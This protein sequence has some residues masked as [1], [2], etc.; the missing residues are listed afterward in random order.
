MRKAIL[1]LLLGMAAVSPVH[2]AEKKNTGCYA[3]ALRNLQRL[4]PRG[5]AVYEAMP[6]KKQFLHWITCGDVPLSLTTAVHE[7]V[8]IMTEQK[9]G[10]V[11]LDGT[12][13]RRP[14]ALSKFYPPRQI[15]GAFDRNDIHVQTYLRPGAASSAQ[16]ATYLLD[17]LNAYTHDLNTAI[18][19]VPM[20]K[21]RSGEAAH[22]D[23][24]SAL[25]AFVM[26]YVENAREKNTATWQGLK[27]PETTKVVRTLWDQAEKVLASSCGIRG[28]G[29]NDK[30]HISFM[31][32][33]K[34]SSALAELLG[35]PAVCARDCLQQGTAMAQ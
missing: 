20:P 28:F 14:H 26:K 34:N 23:G 31:C 1:A 5:Y 3:D 19:L 2:S 22:R 4:S 16:D 18:G 13:L 25:M 29:E 21:G 10:Y 32:Q 11:L 35:R 7:S 12:V 15:A 24:L 33:S 17:E 9:D 6:D 30:K 8:H 27:Q